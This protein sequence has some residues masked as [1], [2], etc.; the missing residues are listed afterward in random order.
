MA[1]R[2]ARHRQNRARQISS[3]G[4]ADTDSCACTARAAAPGNDEARLM[5]L[6]QQ[7]LGEGF[8]EFRQL[9]GCLKGGI[10]GLDAFEGL[11]KDLLPVHNRSILWQKIQAVVSP[12]SARSSA[13]PSPSPRSH[14]ITAAAERGKSA[15]ARGS[16]AGLLF[17]Q[18]TRP[19]TLYPGVGG[20]LGTAD[21]YASEGEG[22][23][24]GVGG[25]A[26]GS[27]SHDEVAV[28]GTPWD[29]G[30]GGRV[31][32]V[33]TDGAAVEGA[34]GDDDDDEDDEDDEGAL[35]CVCFS[36]TEDLLGCGHSLCSLCLVRWMAERKRTCPLCRVPINADAAAEAAAGTWSCDS[37]TYCNDGK[38]AT[39]SLCTA[40]E[41]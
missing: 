33:G 39:C 40:G 16:R 30:G 32:S 4:D 21:G 37:C 28:A 38:S 8:E 31:D 20:S 13:A 17:Y 7:T 23:D 27:Q 24:G 29:G 41:T 36:P 11:A 19:V 10:I 12:P 26:N 9:H 34:E 14:H 6:L 18:P 15:S 22:K 35:C 5:S 2:R 3:L 1:E 25:S